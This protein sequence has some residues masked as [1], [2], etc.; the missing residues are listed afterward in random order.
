MLGGRRVL[1]VGGASGIGRAIA[2]ECVSA[3]ARVV[4]ADLD[5]ERAAAAAEEV[6]AERFEPVDVADEDSVGALFGALVGWDGL[7]GLVNSAG[8]LEVGELGQFSA[9]SW[10]RMFAV[11]ARGQF[12]VLR[13]AL[14]A[15]RH[16]ERPSVVT[17]GSAAAFK[18]GSGNSGYAA[19][20]GA[21]V[22]FS[23]AAA[24]ELA[25]LGI[26]VNA[27][28]P[29]WVETDFNEPAYEAIGGPEAVADFVATSVP[30]GRQAQPA[31]IAAYAAFLLSTQSSYVTGRAVVVDGGML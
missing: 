7:D 11:N 17:I 6:G 5:A 14:P 30:L 18:G 23:N 9:A 22:S 27:L 16:G 31:E 3:G 4:V 25:P 1:V 21:I 8:I 26:R 19:T 29:G 2:A 13:A 12:L 20:K 15:L 10:D 24:M 28:C